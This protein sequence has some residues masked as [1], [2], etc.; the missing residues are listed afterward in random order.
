MLSFIK[1]MIEISIGILNN[2]IYYILGFFMG[3]FLY[4]CIDKIPKEEKVFTK[5]FIIKNKCS[6]IF[7][8]IVGFLFLGVALKYH[9]F[10][11]AKFCTLI[12]LLIVIGVID[13]KTTD[14]YYKTTLPGIILGFLFIFIGMYFNISPGEYIICG[15]VSG[16]LIAIVHL[17]TKGGIGGGD[18]EVFLI[19]GLFLGFKMTIIVFIL[20]F[21]GGGILGLFLVLTRKKTFKD[22]T[23]FIPFITAA[24]IFIIL[25]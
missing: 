22:S 12:S 20:A 14:V 9:G 16:G 5:D 2:V 15:L 10:L 6:Y 19:C 23:S 4:S 8:A 21:T 24:V 13:Y 7:S 3:V 17:L 1:G 25:V 18:A 11:A